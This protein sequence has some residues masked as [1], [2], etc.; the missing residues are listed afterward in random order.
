MF[1][2]KYGFCHTA[3]IACDTDLCI[4]SKFFFP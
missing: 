3:P 4:Y 1:E 2:E